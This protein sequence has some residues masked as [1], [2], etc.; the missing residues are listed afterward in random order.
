MNKFWCGF[1]CGFLAMLCGH[2]FVYGFYIM[3]AICFVVGGIIFV[4]EV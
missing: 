3:A 4:R 2:C 1:I